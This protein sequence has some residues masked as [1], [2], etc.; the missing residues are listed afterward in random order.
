MID[1]K[2]CPFCGSEDLF[3]DPGEYRTDYAIICARCGGRIGY[4][5]TFEY[6]QEAWNR[7]AVDEQR[8]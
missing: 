3:V 2:P 1:I 8:N 7:R 6:A 5:N 4:F